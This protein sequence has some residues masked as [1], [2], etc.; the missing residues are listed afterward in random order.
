MIST[1]NLMTTKDQLEKL[2]K[3][4]SSNNIKQKVKNIKAIIGEKAR[5][6]VSSNLI[7][8]EESRQFGGASHSR[9]LNKTH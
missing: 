1:K 4:L 2:D 7:S 3:I 6:G 5:S 8:P 9:M